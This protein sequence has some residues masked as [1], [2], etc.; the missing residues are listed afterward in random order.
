MILDND[1][2]L[3][4]L[5]TVFLGFLAILLIGLVIAILVFIIL[6]I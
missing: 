3:R 1:T 5:I 2:I 4:T 6:S